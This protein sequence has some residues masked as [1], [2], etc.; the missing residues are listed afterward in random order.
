VSDNHEPSLEKL[1]GGKNPKDL[2]GLKYLGLVHK[3]DCDI[4]ISQRATSALSLGLQFTP[5]PNNWNHSIFTFGSK[6]AKLNQNEIIDNI[7]SNPILKPK[8]SKNQKLIQLFLNSYELQ[9]ILKDHIIAATDK[10]LGPVIVSKKWMSNQCI[11]FLSDQKYF[12]QIDNIKENN[13]KESILKFK[14]EFLKLNKLPSKFIS[15]S[16]SKNELAYFYG[17]VK[18]HKSKPCI[19]PIVAHHSSF[20]SYPDYLL[21]LCLKEIMR[22]C[23][24]IY[25]QWSYFFDNSQ[26]A[27]IRLKRNLAQLKL[28]YGKDNIKPKF[29]IAD[30]ESMYTNIDHKIALD[31]LEY[32]LDKLNIWELQIE[33]TIKDDQMWDPNI[34]RNL[35]G[36]PTKQQIKINR[37][38]IYWLLEYILTHNIFKYIDPS[39]NITYHYIQIKG[40]AMGIH[41]APD[42]AN[43]TLA[44]HEIQSGTS[45]ICPFVSP[46]MCRY[47]DDVCYIYNENS[48]NDY[49]KH[50][51]EHYRFFTG[52]NL[53]PSKEQTFLDISLD[54][55]KDSQNNYKL[56]YSPHIKELKAFDYPHWDSYIPEYIK[57]GLIIGE[58]QRIQRLSSTNEKFYYYANMFYEILIQKR[59]YPRKFILD[60]LKRYIQK[61]LSNDKDLQDFDKKRYIIYDY[62]PYLKLSPILSE[63]FAL[64]PR[65]R[66]TLVKLITRMNRAYKNSNSNSN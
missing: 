57:Y 35:P 22:I 45:G 4:D 40:I 5:I 3:I 12:K 31:N 37:G 19:R 15:H 17:L 1:C 43:L 28:K 18:V 26:Q 24:Q 20:T 41:S 54:I 63:T 27:I 62:M 56:V 47:I 52:L 44:S 36:Y 7:T 39:T 29:F 65:V 21:S 46:Y 53:I 38:Q 10:N 66:P 9:I 42:I 8:S 58:T 64:V 11:E 49:P 33:T 6:L 14:E 25:P 60:T 55:E 23:N 13:E 51:I 32:L 2:S 48:E 34:M 16:T 50:L 61:K 30:F 59:G